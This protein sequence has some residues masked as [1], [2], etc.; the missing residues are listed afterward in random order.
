TRNTVFSC[1]PPSFSPWGRVAASPVS[2]L[3]IHLLLKIGHPAWQRVTQVYINR[4]VV[5]RFRRVRSQEP[6]VTIQPLIL[7]HQVH[8]SVTRIAPDRLVEAERDF[9]NGFVLAIRRSRVAVANQGR[10]ACRRVDRGIAPNVYAAVVGIQ[11]PVLNSRLETVHGAAGV[12]QTDSGVGTDNEI[13]RLT[14]KVAAAA[15]APV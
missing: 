3:Q 6:R 13:G 12:N 4:I 8:R 5:R 7:T 11:L 14:E 2:K 10:L 9:L 1:F 15:V